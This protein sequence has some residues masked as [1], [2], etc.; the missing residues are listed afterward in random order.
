MAEKLFR[1][2]WRQVLELGALHTD[3]HPGNYLVT[4]HPR[5]CL[6]DFGSVR[7]FEPE[8]RGGYLRLAEALLARDDAGIAAACAALGFIDPHD[9]PA[10]MVKIMHVACEPLERDVR[11]D[12]RDYDLLARGAQVAEIAL[13]HRIFRAPGHRVFLLRALVGLDAY[14]KAFG[15]VRNWHRLFREIVERANQT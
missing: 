11:S 14:L 4:H 2:L 5:L 6:L 3:P 1:L 7:L 10:P 8:I 12:P 9:D 15:T 13:A